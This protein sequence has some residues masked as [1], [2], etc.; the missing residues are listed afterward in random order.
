MKTFLS[1]CILF[2]VV[3]LTTSCSKTENRA[4]SSIT[5]EAAP[6]T[7]S[8]R[9]PTTTFP[10]TMAPTAVTLDIVRAVRTGLGPESENNRIQSVIHSRQELDEYLE[11]NEA[12]FEFRTNT[13][14]QNIL[15]TDF[16]ASYFDNHMLIL[17]RVKEGSG[18]IR[19]KITGIHYANK[20]LEIKLQRRA[21]NV[22]TDD[23]A[24]WHIFVGIEKLQDIDFVQVTTTT[25]TIN[26]TT[27]GF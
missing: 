24:D 25:E 4:D 14:L 8:S 13:N 6:S 2:A 19:H 7:E 16:K 22:Q 9:L 3:L 12:A 21:P 17:L 5:S 20:T 23:L 18:S 15:D 27:T 11:K 26:V 10:T 1:V